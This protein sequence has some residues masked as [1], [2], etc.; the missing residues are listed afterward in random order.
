MNELLIIAALVLASPGQT[1]QS[2]TA[3][4]ADMVG[5]WDLTFN[6]PDGPVPAQMNVKKDGDKTGGTIASQ[7]GEN[8]IQVDVKGSGLTIGF[9]FQS[10]NGPMAVTMTGTVDGDTAKGTFAAGDVTG[11]WS[12]SRS[13][14]PSTP[15]KDPS[16]PSVAGTWDITLELPNITATPTLTLKQAGEALTGDYVSAQYGKFPLTGTIKGA[17]VTFS[18]PMTVEGNSYNVTYKGTV[19]KDTMRGYVNIGDMMNGT[20]TAARKK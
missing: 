13:K 17:D 10:P 11:P 16:T 15:S 14:D 9:T 3:A 20:F 5:K 7:Y 4:N 6:P 1:T 18:F 12:G 19:D 8:P 2:T